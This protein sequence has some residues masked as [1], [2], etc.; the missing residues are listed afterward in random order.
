MTLTL[1][2]IIKVGTICDRCKHKSE[3]DALN[4]CLLYVMSDDYQK[5]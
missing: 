3:C 1:S 4:E 2:E 5:E